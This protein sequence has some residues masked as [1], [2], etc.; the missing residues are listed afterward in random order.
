MSRNTEYKFVDTDS[1]AILAKLINKFEE[2]TNRTLKPSDP[3]RL[4]LSWVANAI[5][6]ERVN[7]NYAANQNIPSRA[8]GESLD[9]LGLWIYS[10]P[11]KDKQSSKCTE[12]I[13]ISAPQATSISVPAG[14]RIT[15]LSQALVWETTKDAL[16]P[17]GETYVDVMLQC[18]KAGEIGNGYTEGQICVLIDVDNILYFSHCENITVSDGGAEEQDDDA[19]YEDM[20]SV[21]DSYSTAGAEGSYIY[22]AKSVSDEIADVKAVV[23][24]LHREETPDVYQNANGDR[25]AFLGGEQIVLNSIKVYNEDFTTLYAEGTDYEVDYSDGLLKI[26]VAEN[27]AVATADKIGVRLD[28]QR[29]GYVYLYALMDD[30]TIATQ[31]IKEAILAACNDTDVRPLT[32]YV[33]IHDPEIVPYNIEFTYYISQDTQKSLT[34]IEADVTSAVNTYVEWQCSKLGRDINPDELKAYLKKA[35]VKRATIVS[36][37]F[38]SLRSGANNDVPQIAQIG[39]INVTNGGYEDE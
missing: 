18:Q 5:V 7:L 36:P 14:T 31:T 17:I 15:D 25:C 8:E 26:I 11:R 19:Y 38:T 10:L 37:E 24:V 27:G 9:A 32:D 3:D 30:G 13:H 35:G 23:P 16:I 33:T 4:F 20:R 28:Q 29:A 1:E 22:W 39:T 34:E 12:R 21:L 2:L 6:N